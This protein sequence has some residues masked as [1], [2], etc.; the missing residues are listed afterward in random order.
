MLANSSMGQAP[1]A[2]TLP[3][4][5]PQ[6]LG[7]DMAQ[8][9]KIETLVNE[10]IE[11]GK[12]P[13]CVICFGRHGKIAWLKAY[14]NKRLEPTTKAMTTDTV[15]DMASIT[16][17]TATATSI[18]KLLE[19]GK[20]RLNQAVVDFFP[21]FAPHGKDVITVRDL[22]IHQS[23]L[24]P[25]NSLT[26]YEAGPEAAWQNICELKLVAPVGQEFKY[27]DINFIV[28]AKIV[29]RVSGMNISQFSQEN[30]FSPLH[31]TETGYVP[32]DA[33][34]QRAA[35]TEKRDGVWI[36]GDVHD[37][38]AYLLGGIAGHAGL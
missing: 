33:L 8:L 25:D 38:R 36:Q 13:G 23:G 4:V 16:K 27:S 37:P 22:L 15:F 11:S 19:V 18:M 10:G 7:F 24:V 14:G 29:E 12:M 2:T 3:Q 32:T 31:M 35:P 20:L 21:E 5:D 30:I 6:S 1:S 17:P 28:L 26:D 34:K 9:Q